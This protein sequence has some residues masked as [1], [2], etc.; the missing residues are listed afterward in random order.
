M[1]HPCLSTLH[2]HALTSKLGAPQTTSL[3]AAAVDA[4]MQAVDVGGHVYR[5]T[6]GKEQLGAVA[7]AVAYL[8]V[9]LLQLWQH[10]R[11][12][13]R[14]RAMG[15]GAAS[16]PSVHAVGLAA[17]AFRICAYMAFGSGLLQQSKTLA[18]VVGRHLEPFVEWVHNA[19]SKQVSKWADF[20]VG[21]WG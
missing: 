12:R 16:P 2:A 4:V 6:Q 8:S 7:V 11:G 9:I 19:P 14:S 1:G 3:Q 5:F 18:T 17:W 20:K 15:P 21:R 10:A 13:E